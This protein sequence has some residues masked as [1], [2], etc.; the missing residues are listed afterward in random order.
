MY[1][2]FQTDGSLTRS[3]KNKGRLQIEISRR[4]EDI[5]YK[6]APAIPCYTSI[7]FRKRATNFLPEYESAVLTVCSLQ[8]RENLIRLGMSY[9][10]KSMKLDVPKVRFS[11][12]DYFRETVDGDG[13]LGLT[14]NGFPFLSLCT[15][16]VPM[17]MA[18]EQFISGITSKRKGVRPNRRDKVFN[19][20]VYKEGAQAVV[21]VLYYPGCIALLRKTEAAAKVLAWKRP[22]NM[23]RIDFPKLPWDGEQDRYV[24][25]HTIEES[26]EA[27][28]RTTKSVRIRLWRLRGSNK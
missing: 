28:G 5:L 18:F 22:E 6:I 10:K 15:A 23:R 26:S 7:K 9:G 1:G 21:S 19:L 12:A 14:A 11:E 17:A 16:S 27:L 20:C 3:G 2:L 4:D 13:S 8:F 24:L 25:S